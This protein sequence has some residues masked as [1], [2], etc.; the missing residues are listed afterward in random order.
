MARS[1]AG[2]EA[3]PRA[4]DAIKAAKTVEELC[5]AQ[6]VVLPVQFSMRLE[7]TAQAVGRTTAWVARQRRLFIAGKPNKVTAKNCLSR[8]GRRN[9]LLREDEEDGFMMAVCED[10]IE[11]HRRWVSD[12]RN[13]S[14]TVSRKEVWQNMSYYVRKALEAKL[15]RPVP[16]SSVYNLMNRTGMRKFGSPKPYEWISFC[17]DLIWKSLPKL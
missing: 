11:L 2:W 10:Y 16:L 4:Q 3:L 1:A 14:R 12:D 17:K 13:V 6:A 5:I 15:G 8:G 7:Q 9:Q